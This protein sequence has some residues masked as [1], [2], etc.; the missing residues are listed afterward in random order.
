[1]L[2]S[3]GL[4]KI[5]NERKTSIQTSTGDSANSG[6]FI[7]LKLKVFFKAEVFLYKIYIDISLHATSKSSIQRKKIE[8]PTKNLFALKKVSFEWFVDQTA[9]IE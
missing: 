7:S 4:A 1:M 5:P 2:Q 8:L 3:F 9:G 6:I